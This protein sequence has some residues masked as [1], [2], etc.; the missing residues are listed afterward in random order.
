MAD[1]YLLS[2]I[3][4]ALTKLNQEWSEALKEVRLFSVKMILWFPCRGGGM[5]NTD[6]QNKHTVIYEILKWKQA[7]AG[8]PTQRDENCTEA[9]QWLRVTLFDIIKRF[10]KNGTTLTVVGGHAWKSFC[11]SSIVCGVLTFSESADAKSCCSALIKPLWRGGGQN[12][13][14]PNCIND[15][16]TGKADRRH[17]DRLRRKKCFYENRQVGKKTVRTAQV[18][19][20][21]LLHLSLRLSVPL[22]EVTELSTPWSFLGV[23]TKGYVP[24]VSPAKRALVSKKKK[25]PFVMQHNDAAAAVS[26]SDRAGESQRGEESNGR[27]KRDRRKLKE[28]RKK[29]ERGSM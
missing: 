7:Q 2:L 9:V 22:L 19:R 26:D 28:S 11:K 18:H 23:I 13:T 12:K 25:T 4:F 14:T 27:W 16:M 21:P 6:K 10:S 20:H 17:P 24:R 29:K 3:H 5:N 1:V 15:Q 8:E